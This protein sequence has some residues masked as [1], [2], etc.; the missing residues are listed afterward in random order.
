MIG[1]SGGG[2]SREFGGD[3]RPGAPIRSSDPAP[4][5]RADAVVRDRGHVADRGDLEADRLEGA[6]SA[7]SARAGALDLDLEGADA[8]LGGL[9]AR[10][11][12][13]DLGGIRRR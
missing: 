4:L 6:Q 9:L 11:L 12:G 10:I 2:P 13:G 3:A 1:G 8:V 5:G 7:L